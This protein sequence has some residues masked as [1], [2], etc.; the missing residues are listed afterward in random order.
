MS[1]SE[2][3]MRKVTPPQ[4]PKGSPRSGRTLWLSAAGVAAVIVLI[5]VATHHGDNRPEQSPAASSSNSAMEQK[6]TEQIRLSATGGFQIGD[7]APQFVAA[8]TTGGRFQ[9]S[10]GEPAVVFFMAP[11][12]LSCLAE[13]EALARVHEQYGD[14]LAVLGVDIDPQATAAQIEQFAQAA[15][16]EYGFVVDR[17]ATLVNAFDARALDTTVITDA[18]GRIVFRDAV[19]TDEKTLREALKK[20]GL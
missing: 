18:E 10:P 3:T 9:L 14:R 4:R 12:C 20:A 6:P 1:E 16:A 15:R 17:D 2:S 7:Q 11:T 5:V 13:A 19:P 8:T